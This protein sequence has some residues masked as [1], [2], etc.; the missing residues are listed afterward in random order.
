MRITKFV[1]SAALLGTASALAIGLSAC[2]TASTSTDT[3]TDAATT[4]TASSGLMSFLPLILIFAVMYF[5]L[6]RP[7]QKKTKQVQQMRNDVKPD[8]YVTTIGGFY[9]RVTRV[10]D[11]VITITVGS[12]KTKLD[13]MRWGISKIEKEAPDKGGAAEAEEPKRKP[14]RLSKI[15]KETETSG[16]TLDQE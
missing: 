11:D 1:R 13:I 15:A 7:Q 12:D 14:R 4:S 10:K 3:T 5:I 8:D 6:I 9:G 16:E 2:T